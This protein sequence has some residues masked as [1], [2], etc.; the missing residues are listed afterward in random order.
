MCLAITFTLVL[1]FLLPGCSKIPQTPPTIRHVAATD[2]TEQHPVCFQ[3][4]TCKA[5]RAFVI[6]TEADWKKVWGPGEDPPVIN[7]DKS[8]VLCAFASISSEGPGSMEVWVLKFRQTEDVVE[9]QVKQTVTGSWPLSAGY[10]R[11][12][13]FVK[14][15]KSDKPV[16]VLWRYMWGSRDEET[17]LQAREW[18]PAETSGAGAARWQTQG[19]QQG[20][21]TQ[22]Q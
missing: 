10:S 7:F 13:E 17:E 2:L 22:G 9:A 8:M 1:V 3:A 15:P 16:K 21:P 18:T 19:M 6:K 4:R 12:Y 5:P 20:W 14:L 11:A